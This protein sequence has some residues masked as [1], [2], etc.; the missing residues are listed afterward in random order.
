MSGCR[1]VPGEPRFETASEEHVWRVLG[2]ALP[3][4]AVLIAN[5]RITDE[6]KDHE[7]DLIVLMP[8]V[9]VLVVEV[10]GGSVWRDADGWHQTL[11]RGRCGGSTL[12]TRR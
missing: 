12:R 6:T 2:A 7:A 1:L 11:H 5:F 10:K 3:E 9:G 8:G 4:H